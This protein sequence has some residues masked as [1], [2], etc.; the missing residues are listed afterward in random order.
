MTVSDLSLNEQRDA[1]EM[2]LVTAAAVETGL[3]R[4]LADGPATAADLARRLELDARAV[5]IV[6]GALEP[7][8]LA[9]RDGDVFRLT[10]RALR[11]LADPSSP[12]HAAG[13][14]PHW[15]DLMGT[16]ARLPEALREGGPVGE[17]PVGERDAA[18][19]ARFMAAM[20]SRDRDQ[21][22]RT[23]ELVLA[24]RPGARTVLDLGGGPGVYARAF[25]EAGFERVTLFDRDDALAHVQEAYGVGEV[26]AV[27]AVAGDFLED[28]LPA[29]PY[30]AVLLS[31]I[32][33][34]YPGDAN[35]ALLKKVH[36]VVAPGGVVAIG[37]F[38]RGRSSRAARFAV[39]MLV[40]SQ[41]GDTYDEATY[42]SW[43]EAAGFVDIRID[44]VTD[45]TQLVTGVRR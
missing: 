42:R 35:A 23:V 32:T 7:A 16:F 43:L 30:D 1:A 5:S 10:D 12:E 17:R 22:R 8:G 27:E 37:D 20:A 6:L 44:D 39:V 14:L 45:A 3:F 31:N 25:L 34:I 13:G 19:V 33:H 28:P 11:T 9:V 15:L 38:V 2:V 29:G 40:R 18:G 21:V 4:A 36:G 26:E 24:R 41:G